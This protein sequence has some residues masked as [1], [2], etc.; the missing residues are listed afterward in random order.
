MTRS[1]VYASL[2]VL[3]L[4]GPMT[5]A[6]A[7]VLND[8]SKF[9][10]PAQPL[11]YAL[12]E[13]SRQADVQ[14]MSDAATLKDLRSVEVKGRLKAKD[15]LQQLL[16]STGLGYDLSKNS[17]VVKQ[18][19][20]TEAG[21]AGRSTVGSLSLYEA[22][23]GEGV[24]PVPG[25]ELRRLGEMWVTGT[26]IPGG[27]PVGSSLIVIDRQA[28]ARS[29]YST[30]QDIVRSL[31]QNFGGGPSDD[32]ITSDNTTRGTGLNLRGLGTGATLV[33]FNGRRLAPSGSQAAYTDLSSIPLAAVARIDVMTDGASAI[34]GSD[35]VGGV[36][37]II[38]RDDFQGA[39][40]QASLGSVTDGGLE[41][42][43]ASQLWGA[44]WSSGHV[45]L[46]Y[47][48]YHKSALPASERY[49]SSDSDLRRWGGSN[50]S[51]RFSSP[52]T[53]LIGNQSYA[54]P[55][56][57][58]GTALTADSFIPGVNY[59]N[60]NED[61]D[62]TSE[63]QRHSGLVAMSQSI[64]DS[65]K[66]SA[67]A[68]FAQRQARTDNRGLQATLIVPVSN[69]FRVLPVGASA[70]RYIVQYNFG[71]DLGPQTFRADVDTLNTSAAVKVKLPKKW[72]L[73][74]SLV[75]AEERVDQIQGNRFSQV[76]LAA[77]LADSNPLTAFNPLGDGG[78]NNPATLDRIRR[79]TQF[80]SDSSVKSINVIVTGG[81]VDL[82]G[83]EL[84]L[85]AGSDIREQSFQLKS[86]AQDDIATNVGPDYKRRVDAVFAELVAPIFSRDNRIPGVERLQLSL[87][88]RYDDYSD[89][90]S[91]LNPRFGVEWSPASGVS[92]H[93]TWG[94]SFRAPN[95]T[96]TDERNNM[97]AVQLLPD[98]QSSS[99]ESPV[100]ILVGGN[101]ELHVETAE[102]WSLGVRWESPSTNGL[103]LDLSYF[104]LR[105]KERVRAASGSEAFLSD[106]VRFA[107]LVTRD[108]TLAQRADVCR[109]STFIATSSA[110]D[111]LTAPIAAIVDERFNNVSIAT[112]SGLDLRGMF[113]FEN[114]WGL[115][116]SVAN[117]AYV[118][119]FSEAQ[120]P[121]VLPVSYLDTVGSQLRFRMRH[122]ISW[123]K[124]GFGATATVNYAGGYD[125]TF[126]VPNRDVGSWTTFD[127][128]LSY[129]VE[130]NSR[131][132]L[133]GCSVRLTAQ[134]L[135]DT[136][137]PFV[138]NASGV[139]YDR[140]NADLLNRFVSLRVRKEW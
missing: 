87:A 66:L 78:A 100:L 97:S 138:N 53:L 120:T 23:S 2:L 82:P 39:E 118:L 134:N 102:T 48:F 92:I 112:T 51:S 117:V 136:S 80:A 91:T 37:N 130:S 105:F 12:I 33:L 25:A 24:R 60:L 8:K 62:V 108:P 86:R 128:Q 115:F 64:S 139:G 101:S 98:P 15:A 122:G 47:D 85:A 32:T 137:P 76:E 11:T 42:T 127:L 116:E 96:D 27:E 119:D 58:N 50:F 79:S 61:R 94:T 67:D 17:V 54:I 1:S 38:M 36:V 110:G 74:T 111:C 109:R 133:A 29:G 114:D 31:P 14:V 43:N 73:T 7:D 59:Q 16:K 55:H 70:G 56:N 45:M 41:E 13:W 4:V 69:P 49:Q 99:G 52:G 19:E 88:G 10:I 103:A 30:V 90:G 72:E 3:G 84:R 9:D 140:E 125:D 95:L 35:A 5:T 89:F 46:T 20:M 18:M 63:Q 65:V 22:G 132:W 104:D 126:S 113:S 75:Y 81:L 107:G 44:R 77:A 21:R 121:T 135:F 129:D 34:Y 28:I 6:G 57:Q 40:T 71:G 106:P 26:H 83:G 124:N 131:S 68:F 93:G 123:T